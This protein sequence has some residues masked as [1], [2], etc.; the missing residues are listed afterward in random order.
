MP[1]AIIGLFAMSTRPGGAPLAIYSALG[2][3]KLLSSNGRSGRM[4][5]SMTMRLSSRSIRQWT[6]SGISSAVITKADGSNASPQSVDGYEWH[7]PVLYLRKEVFSNVKQSLQ[8]RRCQSSTFRAKG[9]DL[10]GR[11]P[12]RGREGQGHREALRN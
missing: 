5:G 4:V 7:Q 10:S 8:A 1:E 9:L 12:R 11:R 3:K 2:R 6:S